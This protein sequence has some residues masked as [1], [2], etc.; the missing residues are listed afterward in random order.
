[1]GRGRKAAGFSSDYD[2]SGIAR[3][4]KQ[5]VWCKSP[6]SASGIKC[7]KRADKRCRDVSIDL[8]RRRDHSE[9]TITAQGADGN[10]RAG[11]LW[12]GQC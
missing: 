4:W 8:Q 2:F 7:V 12:Y 9:I 11:C 5:N 1:M 10:L 6:G 3:E